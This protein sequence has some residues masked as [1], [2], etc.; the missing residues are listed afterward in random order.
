MPVLDG[1]RIGPL[2]PD[3]AENFGQ[4]AGGA[5]ARQLIRHH[6]AMHPP[7]LVG[8][9][10]RTQQE[11]RSKAIDKAEAE[12][13]IRKVYSDAGEPLPDESQI[14]GLAIRGEDD[15][16]EL[17]VLTF[18][19]TTAGGRTGKGF[20]PLSDGAR[21]ALKKTMEAGDEAVRIE[22]LKAAG[23][24]WEAK[25]TAQA[26]T[27]ADRQQL[28][29]AARLREEMAELRKRL[30][31]VEGQR[32]TDAQSAGGGSGVQSSPQTPE[33][34]SAR[35]EGSRGPERSQ[36]DAGGETPPDPSQVDPAQLASDLGLTGSYDDAKAQDIRAKLR[37]DDVD[38]NVAR[39]VLAYETRSDGGA[40]RSTVTAAANE[41]LDRKPAAGGE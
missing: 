35:I 16:P 10:T 1:V 37:A 6:V 8:A 21:S 2:D 28:D 27:K 41:V 3:R 13:Y 29:E 38:P 30:E 7:A 5:T 33:G 32:P 40:N 19:Y 36:E 39:R 23:L 15:E 14:K 34:G 24:P 9:L 11:F 26:E 12:K 22:K 31:A 20:V 18:V 17:Q 4:V 25:A